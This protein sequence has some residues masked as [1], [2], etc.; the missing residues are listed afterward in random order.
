M[1]TKII[2][3]L[4]AAAVHGSAGYIQGFTEM[5]TFWGSEQ[6]LCAIY[7]HKHIFLSFFTELS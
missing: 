3:F 7:D 1:G 6:N 2:V 4:D 5:R